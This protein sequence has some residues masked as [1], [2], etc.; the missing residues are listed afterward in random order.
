MARRTT[1]TLLS[2]L[3]LGC[4]AVG[5]AQ[6]AV[7]SQFYAAPLLLN[8]AFAG[9]SRAP[10]ITLNHRSQYVGFG[11][12]NPA[13]AYQTYA[14]TYGQYLTPIRSGIGLSLTADNAGNGIYNSYGASAYYSYQVQIDKKNSVRIGLS[15][16][17]K[18]RRL[19]WDQLIFFDQLDSETG[20]VGP[21]GQPNPT[22]EVRPADLTKTW[23]DFGTGVLYA[24]EVA[25]VG[26]TLDHVT[27]PDDRFASIG[28]GG[29]YKGVPLRISAH[30]GAQIDLQP[31]ARESAAYIVPNLLYAKQGPFEQLNMG[32]YLSFGKIFGGGWFRY[33]FGNADAAIVVIGVSWDMYKFGYSYDATVSGLSSAT[34]GTHEVSLQFDFDKAWWIKSKRQAE[35]YND[36]LNL[37]R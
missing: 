21:N 2:I 22:N 32:A 6:D 5:F 14:I 8:P 3:L 19:D 23:A 7:F 26:V 10:L 29:F 15:A 35:R 16:G 27:T 30:A 33:A 20:A 9:T 17:A 4:A 28:P 36:C 37:F 25:Y 1:S 12:A 31:N 24:G 11:S 13:T 18:Q 34:T